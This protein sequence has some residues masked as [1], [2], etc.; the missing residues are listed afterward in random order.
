MPTTR[1]KSVRRAAAKRT[2]LSALDE[3]NPSNDP[4]DFS[5]SSSSSVKIVHASNDTVSF[6]S[7]SNNHHSSDSSS[8]IPHRPFRIPKD[9]DCTSPDSVNTLLKDIEREVKN[10]QEDMAIKCC[11][12]I[13]KQHEAYFLRGMKIEKSVKKMTIREFNEKFM[14]GL[15]VSDNSD[16]ETKEDV[17]GLVGC[18]DIITMMKS[19]ANSSSVPILGKKRFRNDAHGY[20]KMDLETP[21]RPLRAGNSVR[22]PA[23]ILRTAKRGETLLSVNGS[24]VEAC[25]EGALVATVS[26]K[27]RANGS[28]PT[29]AAMFDINV[30]GRL[31]SLSDPRAMTHLTNE[32]KSTVTQQLNVLQDQIS[33]LMTQIEN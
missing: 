12:A 11:E 25:D 3:N 10:R 32:M 20:G 5:S 31:I 17:G 2:I 16:K 8:S 14:K 26:K 29:G 23:T 18:A 15:S 27:R 7:S 4:F 1:A 6:Q 24:P 22:T 28:N 33:K 21:V 19:I 9:L 13:K 30:G